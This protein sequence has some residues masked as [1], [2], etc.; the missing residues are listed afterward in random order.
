MFP[1]F[2]CIGAQKAGT[3]WLADKLRK[4]PQIEIR[5]KE[6]HYFDKDY[7]L[8]PPLLARTRDPRFWKSLY[9]SIGRDLRKL[10]ASQLAWDMRYH[11]GERNDEWYASLFK[12]SPNLVTGD[13]TPAY[14]A[15]DVSTIAHI[16]KLM[17]DLKIILLLRNP[18]E[19]AW[20]AAGM[21]VR[22]QRFGFEAANGQMNEL[23]AADYI[24]YFELPWVVRRGDYISMINNWER[25]YPRE[26]MFIGFLEDIKQRPNEFL[27]DVCGFLGVDPSPTTPKNVSTPSNVGNNPEMP[28]EIGRYL[29]QTYEPNI[30]TLASYFSGHPRNSSYVNNWLIST[31]RL[32]TRS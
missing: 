7:F 21:N 31:R 14:S 18:I 30:Q 22:K 9:S 12:A 1:N 26:Q 19:R 25:F 11:L 20:S 23:T 13:M 28:I 8:N 32:R 5:R 3:S 6:V 15:L 16:A 17:P 2:M 27:S 4:H 10:S 29:A 24:Q